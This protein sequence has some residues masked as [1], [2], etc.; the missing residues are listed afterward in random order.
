M[1]VR[2][3][4]METVDERGR[5]AY[6]DGLPPLVAGAVH[7]TIESMWRYGLLKPLRRRRKWDALE[8]PAASIAPTTEGSLLRFDVCRMRAELCQF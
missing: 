1:T 2:T 3:D 7:D 6:L 8:S 4:M 5:W